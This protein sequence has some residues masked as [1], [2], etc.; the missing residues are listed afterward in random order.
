MALVVFSVNVRDEVWCVDRP[1][2]LPLLPS[3]LLDSEVKSPFYQLGVFIGV[4]FRARVRPLD[5]YL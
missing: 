2:S 5:P 3:I 1:R 4:I